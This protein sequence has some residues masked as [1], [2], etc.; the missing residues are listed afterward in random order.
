MTDEQGTAA[1]RMQYGRQAAAY[2]T[3]PS[4][5]RGAD[6]GRLIELLAFAGSE[7]AIDVATGTGHTALAIAPHCAEVIGV[8]PTPEMLR[9][10]QAVAEARGVRNVR[11]VLGQAEHLPFEDASC[12]VVT[13][14]RAPHHFQSIP[15]A[16]AEM[17][18]VLRPGG[19]LG[20]V[21]QI[22]PDDPAGAELLERM[23]RRRDPSHVRALSVAEWRRVLAEAGFTVQHVEVDEEVMSLADY[24]DRAAPPPEDRA[25]IH[26]I[27]RQSDPDALRAFGYTAIPRPRAASSSNG[28]WCSPRAKRR[29]W[30]PRGSKPGAHNACDERWR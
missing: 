23:E 18:R 27:L 25:A 8:D 2:T 3:S 13:V 10:A 5:A 29:I 21:D 19:K 11:W 12:D 14:R 6:L 15:A 30:Y 28:S 1:A 9:E 4:H 7:R 17:R 16:L 24:L 22:T 20:L 26:V